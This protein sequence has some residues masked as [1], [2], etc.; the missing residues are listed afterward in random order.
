MAPA[1]LV[2]WFGFSAAAAAVAATTTTV[3]TTVAK[4]HW[5][6]SYPLSQVVRFG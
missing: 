6:S 2:A 5:R 3:T 1:R 4:G